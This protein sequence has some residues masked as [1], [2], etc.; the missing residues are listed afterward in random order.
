MIKRLVST[1]LYAYQPTITI[2]VLIYRLFFIDAKYNTLY[3]QRLN[4]HILTP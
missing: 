4:Q 2:E 3:T 1:D